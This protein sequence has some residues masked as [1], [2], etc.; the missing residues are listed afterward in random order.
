M[1]CFFIEVEHLLAF[2]LVNLNPLESLIAGE[3]MEALG[4]DLELGEVAPKGF[5]MGSGDKTYGTS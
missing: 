2:E 3:L 1:R 4:D 5:R